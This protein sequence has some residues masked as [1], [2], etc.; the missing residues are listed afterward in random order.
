MTIGAQIPHQILPFKF[1]LALVCHP[2]LLSENY[3]F[4]TAILTLKLFFMLKK[5][6]FVTL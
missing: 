5:R 6:L 3:K 1:Y 2:F 4:N